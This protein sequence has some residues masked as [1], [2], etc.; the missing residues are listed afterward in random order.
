MV[1]EGLVGVC[2]QRRLPHSRLAFAASSSKPLFADFWSAEEARDPGQDMMVCGLCFSSLHVSCFLFNHDEH[3]LLGKVIGSCPEAR[4]WHLSSFRCEH[5]RSSLEDNEDDIV[6]MSEFSYPVY[7]AFLEYLYTDSI[8]LSPEEAVGNSPQTWP[9]VWQK[10]GLC[11]ASKEVSVRVVRK[12][13]LFLCA[14]PKLFPSSRL[15]QRLIWW[16]K[17][18]VGELSTHQHCGV[19]A[20][21]PELLD[22]VHSFLVS[23]TC[24]LRDIYII[25]MVRCM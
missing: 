5:F 6:E 21:Q 1:W 19:G 10:G 12:V 13:V 11:R 17:W 3:V 8:S 14:K 24:C 20:I 16:I 4:T 2:G 25:K 23:T 9:R 7:R 22:T 18:E 15:I